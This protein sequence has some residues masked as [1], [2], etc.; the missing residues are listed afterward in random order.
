MPKVTEPKGKKVEQPGRKV[1]KF[2]G[3][4]GVQIRVLQAM[5]SGSKV[6][7]ADLSEATGISKGW[8]K[9]LGTREDPI[10]GSLEGMGLVRKVD[11][12]KDE[13][14]ILTYVITAD[15]KK[16]LAKAEKEMAKT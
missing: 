10:E 5:S 12:P 16:M 14:Q 8:A 13:K 9:I 7:R 11:P 6:T 1:Q 15:G 4:T 3:L 2:A